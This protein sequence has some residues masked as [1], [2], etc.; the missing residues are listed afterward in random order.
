MQTQDLDK[1]REIIALEARAKAAA[2]E[3]S[4]VSLRLNSLGMEAKVSGWD[5]KR[6]G[7]F[8][9]ICPQGGVTVRIVSLEDR[10]AA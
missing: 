9:E 10:K 4:A 2:A 8:A 3:L 6:A 7:S 5:W 1:A